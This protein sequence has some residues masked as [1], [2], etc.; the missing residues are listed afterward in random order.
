MSS[1]DDMAVAPALDLTLVDLIAQRVLELLATVLADLGDAGA[2]KPEEEHTPEG[3]GRAV[4][5]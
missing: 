3:R 5:R 4:E 1:A 2:S